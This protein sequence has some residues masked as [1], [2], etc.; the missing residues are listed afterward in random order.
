MMR[1]PTKEETMAKPSTPKTQDDTQPDTQADQPAAE[2][3]VE[4]TREDELYEL[5]EQDAGAYT[6]VPEGKV[7]KNATVEAVLVDG[8]PVVRGGLVVVKRKK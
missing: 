1:S 2:A 7:A 8:K 6:L 4:K 3:P 5:A